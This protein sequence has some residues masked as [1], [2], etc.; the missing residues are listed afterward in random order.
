MAEEM[1][2]SMMISLGGEDDAAADGAAPLDKGVGGNA[3]AG[4]NRDREYDLEGDMDFINDM[5]QES[6]YDTVFKYPDILTA[7]L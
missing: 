7:R 2:H 4:S 3:A 6:A 1:A 5:Q